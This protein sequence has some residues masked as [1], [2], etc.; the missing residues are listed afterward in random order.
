MC[1]EWYDSWPLSAH[2]FSK[3]CSHVALCW[4]WFSTRPLKLNSGRFLLID[5]RFGWYP[6]QT[7]SGVRFGSYPVR[8]V[9][10]S[11]L[12]SPSSLAS[13]GSSIQGLTWIAEACRLLGPWWRCRLSEDSCWC[14]EDRHL[15][16]EHALEWSG[17]A[18]RYALCVRGTPGS[19]PDIYCSCCRS[20]WESD[21][22]WECP[23][24]SKSSWAIRLHMQLRLRPC[25]H[26]PYLKVRQ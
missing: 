11:R 18:L 26:P 19:E 15:R 17:S 21:P 6:V 9:S 3:V 10:S 8:M 22:W 20:K 5:V 7:I 12:Y 4:A 1:R 14:V 25:I 23:D 2:R 13:Q 16:P 24:P